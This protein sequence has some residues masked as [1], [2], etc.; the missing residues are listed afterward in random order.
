ML[1]LSH[2]I[3][4]D[5]LV[6]L[7]KN[8]FLF[9]S[10]MP[11]GLIEL[12]TKGNE[13]IPLIYN[14][15]ITFFTK[16]YHKHT[17]FSIN[18]NIKN[19]IKIK[20]GQE[21]NVIM[22]KEGDLLGQLLLKVD[23]P[24]F[25][26]IKNE[27]T[28]TTVSTTP[29]ID[30][31]EMLYNN[32]NVYLYNYKSK[33]YI[34][35]ETL[36][37]KSN[38][39]Y[40]Q[41]NILFSAIKD[42]L[43]LTDFSI[44]NDHDDVIFYNISDNTLNSIIPILRKNSSY[45]EEEWFNQVINSSVQFN[46]NILTQT[47]L[48]KYLFTLMEESLYIDY[49]H[50]NNTKPN[51][52]LYQIN[53][54]SG[55]ELITE[56]KRY[57][58]Y[59]NNIS[60]S[61]IGLDIDIS[62]DYANLKNLTVNKTL[63]DTLTYNSYILYNIIKQMYP[64]KT[65]DTS[66]YDNIFT[67]WKKY[68]LTYE[69]IIDDAYQIEDFNSNSEW[70]TNF[71]TYFEGLLNVNEVD[72]PLLNK[73]LMSYYLA[74][75]L[76]KQKIDTLVISNTKK[77][78][79][80]LFTFSE[81]FNNIGN[82]SNETFDDNMYNQDDNFYINFKDFDSYITSQNSIDSRT[83]YKNRTESNYLDFTSNH[84][85]L[86]N[87][88]SVCVYDFFYNID[89]ENLIDEDHR[90]FLLW[91][92]NK[93]NNYVYL[94]YNRIKKIR[95]Y[96]NLDSNLSLYVNLDI[97]NKM[98]SYDIR[99]YLEQLF[100][101]YSYIGLVKLNDEI[102]EIST[103][104]CSATCTTNEKNK[105]WNGVSVNLTKFNDM[106]TVGLSSVSTKWDETLGID[107]SESDFLE[108][109][110]KSIYTISSDDYV[111]NK[112][113][114]KVADLDIYL[115]P[116]TEYN[117]YTSTTNYKVK[118]YY[119]SGKFYLFELEE[120]D[121]TLSGTIYLRENI[122]Q[123]I[124]LIKIE[125]M[126]VS[127]D[128][129]VVIKD[130][131]GINLDE[132]FI[133][134][135]V[136]QSSE[137]GTKF[138][139]TKEFYYDKVLAVIDKITYLKCQSTTETLRFRVNITS[140][141]TSALSTCS[142]LSSELCTGLNIT[143][144]TCTA[145]I[146]SC[147]C[148]TCTSDASG[149]VLITIT[150]IDVPKVN[151]LNYDTI[152]LEIYHLPIQEVTLDYNSYYDVEEG[153]LTAEITDGKI[154]KVNIVN[155]GENYNI[156][157]I[158]LNINGSGS[159]AKIKANMTDGRITSI[160]IENSGSGYDIDDIY[161]RIPQFTPVI[162]SGVIT[163]VIINRY[164]SNY[165]V[166]DL[167]FIKEGNGSG[168][169]MTLVVVNGQIDRID[170]NDGGSSHDSTTII[171]LFDKKAIYKHFP[172]LYINTS[173]LKTDTK[174]Y[175]KNTNT[176]YL[177]DTDDPVRFKSYTG[178]NTLCK[179]SI[180]ETV[181]N[182]YLEITLKIFQN[183]Y[184]PNLFN[185]TSLNKINNVGD[186]MDYFIQQPMIIR[187]NAS[188][189]KN[190]SNV[191][192][193]LYCFYNIPF[194]HESDASV[195][196]EIYL[197]GYRVDVLQK[198]NSNQLIR[199]YKPKKS[200]TKKY[201]TYY[202]IDNDRLFSSSYDE[203]SNYNLK[204][205]DSYFYNKE[206][207]LTSIMTIFDNIFL[208]TDTKYSN[209]T[210][211]VD[212]MQIEY[213]KLY[214]DIL[215]ILSN[216]GKTI[217]QIL[218]N[219][220]T[221]NY[222][223][224]ESTGK[225]ILL[226]I[227]NTYYDDFDCITRLAIGLY[228]FNKYEVDSGYNLNQQYIFNSPWFKYSPSLRINSEIIDFI[229]NYS[230]NILDN[231]NY[232]N[233]N[234][235]YYKI[236]NE[237]S[238]SEALGTQENITSIVKK[239]AYVEPTFNQVNFKHPI[240]DIEKILVISIV[241]IEQELALIDAGTV[242]ETLDATHF[243]YTDVFKDEEVT[244]TTATTVQ[245][246]SVDISL[247]DTIITIY[248]D[249]KP[250]TV[251]S[252]D[253]DSQNLI[254]KDSL[255][256]FDDRY[257]YKNNYY[258]NN[259]KNNCFSLIG[260]MQI[261]NGELI[262]NPIITYKNTL[263]YYLLTDDNQVLL[264]KDE[265]LSLNS[266]IIGIN[267]NSYML[268]MID[269][270][271]SYL[272]KENVI[273][274]GKE[275]NCYITNSTTDFILLKD[276]EIIQNINGNTDYYIY[277]NKRYYS[278]D[279]VETTEDTLIYVQKVTV[280][281]LNIPPYYTINNQIKL[282]DIDLDWMTNKYHWIIINN[283]LFQVIDI[284]SYVRYISD[285]NY[286]IR[287]LPSSKLIVEKF[288]SST[289]TDTIT[290]TV[291]FT[292]SIENIFQKYGYI[293]IDGSYYYINDVNTSSNTITLNEN[294]DLS[295]TNN[296][297]YYFS[298]QNY[299]NS[300]IYDST[301]IPIYKS[302]DNF[303]MLQKKECNWEL[304]GDFEITNYKYIYTDNIIEK[305]RYILLYNNGSYQFAQVSAV[306]SN[307]I[308]LSQS[309]ELTNATIFGI[310]S[311]P[312]FISY[313]LCITRNMNEVLIETYHGILEVSDII[314]FRDVVIVITDIKTYSTKLTFRGTII[315]SNNSIPNE[316]NGFYYFGKLSNYETRYND[317][318]YLNSEGY[319][320]LK[321]RL[322]IVENVVRTEQFL[323]CGDPYIQDNEL[324]LAQE[325]VDLNEFKLNNGIDLNLYHDGNGIWLKTDL[326]IKLNP[327]MYLIYSEA[328][329][330]E[331]CTS[332]CTSTCTTTCTTISAFTKKHF[333]YVKQ[334]HFGKIIWEDTSVLNS[335][336][337][338]YHSFYLPIQPLERTL[339]SVSN[340]LITSSEQLGFYDTFTGW[341]EKEDH[342]LVKV[343]DNSVDLSDGKYNVRIYKIRDTSFDFNNPYSVK[344]YDDNILNDRIPFKYTMDLIKDD[345]YGIY[346]K[347]ARIT[348]VSNVHIGELYFTYNHYIWVNGYICK[349]VDLKFI[350][351]D[352]QYDLI[353]LDIS[354]SVNL[355]YGQEVEVIFSPLNVIN[356][357]TLSNE[358]LIDSRIKIDYPNI[359][360]GV[361]NLVIYVVDVTSD[362]I[363]NYVFKTII[364][365][366]SSILYI[367]SD[368]LSN[369]I[370][371]TNTISSNTYYFIDGYIPITVETF[372]GS[373]TYKIF[374]QSH[375]IIKDSYHIV[376]EHT[377]RNEK[378]IH[379]V[380]LILEN[381]L[382]K[383]TRVDLFEDTTTSSF[384]INKIIPIRISKNGYVQVLS[385]EIQITDIINSDNQNKL[386]FWNSIPIAVLGKPIKE[387]D[388]W[389]YKA[390]IKL[391]NYNTTN[392][393]IV[394]IDKKYVVT[395]EL[396]TVLT[397]LEGLDDIIDIYI[398]SST[399]ILIDFDFIF[400]NE[401]NIINSVA[402]ATNLV[403]FRSEFS[404][405]N[406][407]RLQYLINGDVLG[408]QLYLK[409]KS[410]IDIYKKSSSYVIK[411]KKIYQNSGYNYFI[412]YPFISIS[413][414]IT[415]NDNSVIYI[416][417]TL[418][419]IG[420]TSDTSTDTSLYIESNQSINLWKKNK[421]LSLTTFSMTEIIKKEGL[422]F[423]S[424]LNSHKPW[425]KLS[426]LSTYSNS[427]LNL[428][429][430]GSI[431]FTQSL[432]NTSDDNVANLINTSN[433][434]NYFTTVELKNLN[435][436][437]NLMF[438]HTSIDVITLVN[439]MV[440]LR[441]VEK[442]IL[443]QLKKLHY[444][445]HFWNNVETTINSLLKICQDNTLGWTL[446]NGC[447]I[448]KVE[449]D[450]ELYNDTDLFTQDENGYLVRNTYW[451]SQYTFC[452]TAGSNSG[453]C[454]AGCTGEC[455]CTS[456]SNG[457]CDDSDGLCV[458]VIRNIGDNSSLADFI[459]EQV[460]AMIKNELISNTTYVG[461]DFAKL[462]IT[463]LKISS[464][465]LTLTDYLNGNQYNIFNYKYISSL[466]LFVNKLWEK[467]RVDLL[468]RN[469]NNNLQYK[470]NINN[471]NINSGRYTDYLF[472]HKFYGISSF[473]VFNQ[474]SSDNTNDDIF[475]NYLEYSSHLSR[476]NNKLHLYLDSDPIFPYKIELDAK[477][478]DV[479][480]DYQID[481]LSG[482]YKLEDPSITSITKDVNNLQFY[483]TKNF[484]SYDIALIGT[485]KYAV[486]SYIKIGK[487]YKTRLVSSLSGVNFS[488][489]G[490]K[491]Y[492]SSYLGPFT[493]Y[494]TSSSGDS[495][496]KVG[497][498]YPL[499]TDKNSSDSVD[500]GNNTI[501]G[502]GSHS[503]AF[504]DHPGITFYMP[505]SNM[506]HSSTS[507]PETNLLYQEQI[508]LNKDYS[509]NKDYD[510]ISPFDLNNI[511]YIQVVQRVNL[512]TATISSGKTTF[513][514]DSN[515]DSF[516]D[517]EIQIFLEIDD[518][519]YQILKSD[520]YYTSTELTLTTNII[521]HVVKY[522]AIDITSSISDLELS[523][524][525]ITL[526]REIDNFVDYI[527]KDPLTIN[528][529][530]DDLVINDVHFLSPNKLRVIYTENTNETF[531]QLK[532]IVKVDESISYLVNSIYAKSSDNDTCTG[533]CTGIN[534]TR[535]LS[536]LY[537]INMKVKLTTYQ[538]FEIVIYDSDFVVQEVV[539]GDIYQVYADYILV[540]LKLSS[541]K[542]LS[543]FSNSSYYILNKW[544]FVNSELTI[545]SNQVTITKPSNFILED[546]TVWNYQVDVYQNNTV[547]SD[548][549][550]NITGIVISGN[551]LIL[552]LESSITISV[553][554]LTLKQLLVQTLTP[555]SKGIQAEE[556]NYLVNITLDE[557][558]KI[559]KEE[560]PIIRY[561]DKNNVEMADGFMYLFVSKTNS[562]IT[563]SNH[564][565]F[566]L[567][568][569][570]N[571]KYTGTLISLFKLDS[572]I[573]NDIRYQFVIKLT[574]SIDVSSNFYYHLDIAGFSYKLMEELKEYGS[575][576]TR[577]KLYQQTNVYDSE[578]NFTNFVNELFVPHKS[579]T[580][581]YKDLEMT[582]NRIF[583]SFE[584]TEL[585]LN[586]I[587]ND[588]I[589]KVSTRLSSS[590]STTNT[591]TNTTE[592][593]VWNSNLAFK[594]F[595]HIIFS[596]NGIIID[597]ITPDTNLIDY[598]YNMDDQE[599]DNWN[600]LVKLNST[601]DGYR[602]YIPLHLFFN[603]KSFNYL[604]LIS[605]INTD[606]SFK[607]KMNSLEN[608]I[609]NTLSAT[610]YSSSN[611]ASSISLIY[612]Y[613]LLDTE[614]RELF[615]NLYHEYIIER[616]KVYPEKMLTTT[617]NDIQI[618]LRNLVKSIFLITQVQKDKDRTYFINETTVYDRWYQDYLLKYN[619]YVNYTNGITSDVDSDNI[620][621]FNNLT[622][623]FNLGSSNRVKWIKAS[624]LLK[625]KNILLCLFLDHTY[626]VHLADYENY[627]ENYK[628]TRIFCLEMYFLHIHQNTV[629]KTPISIIE[630]LKIVSSGKELFRY[631]T[632]E[633]FNNVLSHQLFK[634]EQPLGYYCYSFA[635][636]PTKI[637][638]S[639]HLNFNRL[640]DTRIRAVLNSKVE[641]EEVILK[642][643][644]KEY[645]ILRIM[646]GI[647]GIAWI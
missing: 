180:I 620:I 517:S 502:P 51:I 306:Y 361:Y 321:N 111:L 197:N 638:P 15:Q 409:Y 44:I 370:D 68:T 519:H 129:I 635:L 93:I 109:Y 624:P 243:D 22:N 39:E 110:T 37:N 63:L 215:D 395:L 157:E 587:F 81:R 333:V 428:L 125:D 296:T 260:I 220:N 42:V 71:N 642:I 430:R 534:E 151:I 23:I 371:E 237:S 263:T 293:E 628:P 309:T 461:I 291:T 579:I 6:R 418:Y 242:E 282:I 140:T 527:N 74:E 486:E 300:I 107:K 598:Y 335:L 366:I 580:N 113:V 549:I 627:G 582:Q 29:D 78:W 533:T 553:Y 339:I 218:V 289:N 225:K 189:V 564:N 105:K 234:S 181:R 188:L 153:I 299:I 128:N 124:P 98:T 468:N 142:N 271:D 449:K 33:W 163:E 592:D 236:V 337:K 507:Y 171:N 593:I 176:Y 594:L 26:I 288:I 491:K 227:N 633:Y 91:F 336:S 60:V 239:V 402:P 597:K 137:T 443:D 612:D 10:N 364:S 647:S 419:D 254:V 481:I 249:D 494:G 504:Y 338:G 261:I 351:T 348:S 259:Y 555:G 269:Q 331:I 55:D 462:L 82:Y 127:D 184:L 233:S 224:I 434:V 196:R 174:S 322:E 114:L 464:E 413:D 4:N 90:H 445:N 432:I 530:L 294:V 38:R 34:F 538:Y 495:I 501:L 310:D 451:S 85:D 106:E 8:N 438:T 186:I 119:K 183:K 95:T 141:N 96:T 313:K 295:D 452:I 170:I 446:Y 525:D 277:D 31:L 457:C 423:A 298:P 396:I 245:D 112:N 570:T 253:K 414:I 116:L 144:T 1:I 576:H 569:S 303:D 356:R 191:N 65:Y 285:G 49:N 328:I 440:E 120:S 104:T 384:Y 182:N 586:N 179:L 327:G 217:N 478:I 64:D 408:K 325:F 431:K 380:K 618:N 62:Y 203:V 126:T 368:D 32:Y 18:T 614:E 221:I 297:F 381:N 439:N 12:V 156:D 36:F 482:P 518:V 108:L 284:E 258:R 498:F 133:E 458:I 25:N 193:P 437:L 425:E 531:S 46:Q 88:Y 643:I 154:T 509:E 372:A 135:I 615:A 76:I 401:I 522:I 320:F 363:K 150:Y 625:D 545:S 622:S 537:K 454:T 66:K 626:F 222:Y 67:F 393:Q 131:P 551:N 349:M 552:T 540:I 315:S 543:Y 275:Y 513:T 541:Y 536:F 605:L 94:R 122:T 324:K 529:K 400:F 344:Y 511:T 334:N 535:L 47:T 168:S 646:S 595:E 559:G 503:H 488:I 426:L 571:I 139:N 447:F 97:Q 278:I 73:L 70:K 469:F 252:L 56:I 367:R 305:L 617:N 387:G 489:Y 332:T 566:I 164:G 318:F 190:N 2:K 89:N 412:H 267:W 319:T 466:K 602:I 562:E 515:F 523:V 362:K 636:N 312:Y 516:Y 194:K 599:Q 565:I 353:I 166:N 235:D 583:I 455:V 456:D 520:N 369:F 103:I 28:S 453:I 262:T 198:L 544:D 346:L 161:F 177:K 286:T 365:T 216:Y 382:P 616:Y 630:K 603:R 463:I 596:L 207:V 477:L 479:N 386:N 292:E 257:V 590:T 397:G 483:L 558:Y 644:T 155:P 246:T 80:E 392:G 505:N 342:T 160:T 526:T 329:D 378:Y 195:T 287:Y 611:A 585:K 212:T 354:D 149:L 492:K 264:I 92:R 255:D 206:E 487:V 52:K 581:Y 584:R 274:C 13:D 308:L 415:S 436:I 208:A 514:F 145:D 480:M 345:T 352:A 389:K 634:S 561:L 40:Y 27:T 467:N 316:I 441:T 272:I 357:L 621:L 528:F 69:N 403:K 152:S 59:I 424:L 374:P 268:Q 265:D 58:D 499:Y 398:V 273:I 178:N 147:P 202:G 167:K 420:I 577:T 16:V 330:S 547:A 201:A 187:M 256:E 35:P 399:I 484:K 101:S 205:L 158:Y 99:N 377:V 210:K 159:D 314:S 421:E 490:D 138:V 459:D 591:I 77:I 493:V 546:I 573:K 200:E 290:S 83:E 238:N 548:D 302:L 613:V 379:F 608:V 610:S 578:G 50:F 266:S 136:I 130:T 429:H 631:F 619:E 567:D 600:K 219:S 623:E 301:D 53:F 629:E 641:E 229:K 350:I 607:I 185:Y 100:Y 230:E 213:V 557:P 146:D 410:D 79:T 383:F 102:E 521:Y 248:Q 250:L 223:A 568:T 601:V 550:I 407:V 448:T 204:N 506:N 343:T 162:S 435:R 251:T 304:F 226:D 270:I 17:N 115:Q 411:D 20:W 588:F 640:D 497:Y 347:R 7:I 118:K 30:S 394:Y 307:Y 632:S 24:S 556:L 645:Q 496:D 232:Y 375:S 385:P 417:K 148:P 231:L 9:F 473:N 117:V 476:I 45:L 474:L 444:S 247:R 572:D 639:G 539:K 376:E 54:T 388:Y 422:T 276:G 475:V 373:N 280:S 500:D 192:Y 214:T 406:D 3:T 143:D 317:L 169:D 416:E 450:S 21:N 358:Y 404:N 211:L 121:I 87:I 41:D 86:F 228:S 532:H 542:E 283:N 84:S 554:K 589:F 173:T 508:Y 390:Q 465:R 323:K 48:S 359:I 405:L 575:L 563:F 244:A 134:D 472:N 57:L 75:E 240:N 326:S 172:L 209:I 241:D 560:T 460:T 433:I 311:E 360:P 604:P 512:K 606:I 199:Y 279:F 442:F 470:Y 72:I 281:K 485:E 341:I 637:Q 574:E 43:P 340:K 391:G 11:G 355:T 132:D 427:N 471:S 61:N 175:F 14:P 5:K 19:N 123:S 524:V 165:D 609:T 510:L